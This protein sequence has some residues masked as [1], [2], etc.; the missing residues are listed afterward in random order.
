LISVLLYLF[1][2]QDI[3]KCSFNYKAS[4]VEEKNE[5]L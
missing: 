2:F 1:C 3:N 4:L 5:L